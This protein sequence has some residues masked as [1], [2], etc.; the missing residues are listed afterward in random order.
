MISRISCRSAQVL[1]PLEYENYGLLRTLE[2]YDTPS[3][4]VAWAALASTTLQE[5][6]AGTLSVSAELT[7]E[8]PT[9]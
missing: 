5:F 4:V 9:K 3:L 2:D 1:L 6:A 8:L 7:P